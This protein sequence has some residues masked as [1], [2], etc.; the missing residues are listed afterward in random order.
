MSDNKKTEPVPEVD[1]F[2]VENPAW[3]YGRKKV[4]LASDVERVVQKLHYDLQLALQQQKVWQDRCNDWEKAA[5][6]AKQQR[7]LVRVVK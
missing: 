1:S 5:R 6:L 4:C 3:T 2:W 7:N